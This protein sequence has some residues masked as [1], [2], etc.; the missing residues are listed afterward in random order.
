VQISAFI[1]HKCRQIY[2][3]LRL[4]KRNIS[5]FW[6]S[7]FR[8]IFSRYTIPFIRF[9]FVLYSS[10]IISFNSYRPDTRTHTQPTTALPGPLKLRV[11]CTCECIALSDVTVICS[12]I[13][14][15][16]L[17][18]NTAYRV[19]LD[20][21]GEDLSR[22]SNNTESVGLRKCSYCHYVT[23][24]KKV[25]SQWE[26]FARA[27][28][29]YDHGGKTAGMD[30]VRRN[31]VTVT[32]CP[33]PR[34]PA[35]NK[36]RFLQLVHAGISTAGVTG[37]NSGANGKQIPNIRREPKHAPYIISWITRTW[38]KKCNFWRT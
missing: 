28:T 9:L 18:G 14:I 25:M 22:Y 35:V 29:T 4:A 13:T 19:K 27:C 12:H 31:Y 7:F 38:A 33:V 37:I 34:A 36:W 17:C 5:A 16:V 24:K 30:K 20:L 21:S 23:N 2:C 15:F 26:T 11:T 1:H 10:R 6:G 3:T 8:F 32:L